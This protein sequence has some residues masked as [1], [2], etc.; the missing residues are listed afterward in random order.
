MAALT[1]SST[2]KSGQKILTAFT[3]GK[4]RILIASDRASR[5]L[6]VPNLTQVV[7][8]DLPRS[9]T[10]Y[11]HRVGRTARAGKE[12][13]LGLSSQREKVGGSGT[14]IA[15]SPTIRRGGRKVE[16]AKVDAEAVVTRGEL[17]MRL[18]LRMLQL[19]VEGSTGRAV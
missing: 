15:R 18:A 17:R 1:K 5:G 12:G 11:V 19:A 9:V 16:R 13:K 8:Y 10:N 4:F 2:T 3:R 7:N 6:D 14:R